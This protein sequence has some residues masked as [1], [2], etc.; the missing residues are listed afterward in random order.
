M[1]GSPHS[2]W[3]H[4]DFGAEPLGEITRYKKD[5]Q[6]VTVM[7]VTLDEQSWAGLRQSWIEKGNK[8]WVT[9]TVAHEKDGVVWVSVRL[10]C[11][12]LT[13]GSRLPTPKKPYLIKVLLQRLGGGYDGILPIDAD[14]VR[15]REDEVDVAAGY[16]TGTARNRLPVVYVSTDWGRQYSL[17]VNR[18]SRDLAGMAHVVVEPSRQ[19]SFALNRNVHGINAYNGAVSIYWPAGLGA[20]ARFLPIRFASATELENAI[21]EAVRVALTHIRPRV[22]STSS[23]LREVISRAR[24][25]QLRTQGSAGWEEYAQEIDAELSAVRQQLD[26]SEAE[27]RRLMGENMRL[28]GFAKTRSEG[29]LALGDEQEF[30]PGEITE[31]IAAALKASRSTIRTDSRWMH[32]IEDLIAANPAGEGAEQIA[33]QIKDI[34]AKGGKF[35]TTERRALEELGFVV[36]DSGKHVKAVYHGDDRYVFSI[37]KTPSDSRAGKNLVSTINNKIFGA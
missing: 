2:K 14:P 24:L 19:F 8:E 29:V 34:F 22:E 36:T 25:Q 3:T 23:Y 31:C 7:R 13:P 28:Q 30:Y 21:R 15:L 4:E 6:E 26:E 9:D 17:D 27:I 18:L 5:A 37:S 35:G 20:Q 32:I 11:N 1:V 16:M 12:L 33:S 10:H